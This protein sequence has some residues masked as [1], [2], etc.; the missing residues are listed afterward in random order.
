MREAS[1]LNLAEKML[2]LSYV[3]DKGRIS[4]RASGTIQYIFTAVSIFEL[5]MKRK[6]RIEGRKLILLD[7]SPAGDEI[8][9]EILAKISSKYDPKSVTYWTSALSHGLQKK[10]MNRLEDKGIFWEDYVTSMFLFTRKCYRLSDSRDFKVLH[11][12]MREVLLAE[13]ARITAEDVILAAMMKNC[14]I[15]PLH[16]EKGEMAGFKARMTSF[17]KDEGLL[18]R[19]MGSDLAEA[20]KA[21]NKALTEVKAATSGS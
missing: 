6:T 4:Y 10:M 3:E 9:D 7:M 8:L 18:E 17:F 20:Y 13:N 1:K 2:L 11:E 16:F 15:L 14:G 19:V 21:V 12:R 5:C